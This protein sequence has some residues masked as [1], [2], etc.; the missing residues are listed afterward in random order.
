MPVGNILVG[1]PGG[2]VEH[3]DTT[4]TVDVVAVS[5]SSELLLTGSIPHIELELTKVGEEAKRTNGKNLSVSSSDK[6]KNI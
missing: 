1:D 6:K 3:D 4:F 5:Q 2:N